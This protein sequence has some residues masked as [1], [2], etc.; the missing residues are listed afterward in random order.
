MKRF[1]AVA[2]NGA[3]LASLAVSTAGATQADRPEDRNGAPMELGELEVHCEPDFCVHWVADAQ[4]PDAPDDVDTDPPNGLPDFV[5][6]TIA[7]MQTTWDVE[8]DQLGFRQPLDD[9]HPTKEHGPD[10]RFDLYLADIEK[11]D[12]GYC[13]FGHAPNKKKPEIRTGYCVIDNDYADQG[14]FAGQVLEATVAHEF[15]HAV[16]FAY[17]AWDDRWMIEGTA[18]WI[19][20]V[21]FDDNNDVYGWL[22]VSPLT[23]PHLSLD[24]ATD[25]KSNLAFAPYGTWIFWRFLGERLSTTG[26]HDPGVIKDVWEQVDAAP[27]SP[28]HSSLSGVVEVIEQRGLTF[29][30]VFLNFAVANLDLVDAY[31][32]GAAMAAALEDRGHSPAPPTKA[33]LTLGPDRQRATVKGRLQQ[34]STQYVSIT[35][36]GGSQ[37]EL[38][39]DLASR[40]R[41][42]QAAV[43]LW[44]PAGDPEVF[45]LRLNRRGD[46]TFDVPLDGAG[47]VTLVLNNASTRY[48]CFQDTLLSCG[49]E[50]KDHKLRY[51]LKAAVR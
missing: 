44:D 26:S 34:L 20:D 42:S 40:K 37:L 47:E 2:L 13:P 33:D 4:S 10:G 3:L 41:G 31:E 11:N 18:N 35:P 17:D 39:L 49:G 36:D 24:F 25:K 43:V 28:D 23:Y 38:S 32:E 21:V 7:A 27:G 5:D 1:A 30:E 46:G 14:D 16:Q 9:T 12:A 48:R 50:P 19:E 51:V 8:I 45:T 22:D 29:K 6:L 15:F